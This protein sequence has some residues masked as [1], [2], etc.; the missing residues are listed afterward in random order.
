MEFLG[1]NLPLVLPKEKAFWAGFGTGSQRRTCF[2]LESRFLGVLG[3]TGGIK[4][5]FCWQ[6]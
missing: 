6:N 2:D 3:G 1:R 4:F 5:V